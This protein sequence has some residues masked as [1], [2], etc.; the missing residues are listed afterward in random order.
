VKVHPFLFFII[1]TSYTISTLLHSSTF[2][3]ETRDHDTSTETPIYGTTIQTYT[4]HETTSVMSSHITHL[5]KTNSAESTLT[6][7][8]DYTTHSI[9]NIVGYKIHTTPSSIHTSNMTRNT[10]TILSIPSHS[11]QTTVINKT[12]DTPSI[13]HVI[14]NITLLSTPEITTQPPII[15]QNTGDVTTR[16]SIPSDADQ[17]K[18]FNVLYYIY[19]SL[20]VVLLF[21]FVG[22]CL[23]RLLNHH[24][25][26]QNS[27]ETKDVEDYRTKMKRR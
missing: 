15:T 24:T 13:N 4:D 10:I 23:Y 11:K 6:P 21:V 26:K 14:K 16:I 8:I 22:A 5:D 7:S 2:H 27:I 20:P 18:I 1:D 9:H 12:H 17:S 19:T 25:K 3:H